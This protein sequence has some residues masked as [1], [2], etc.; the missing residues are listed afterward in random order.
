ME[1]E[2]LNFIQQNLVNPVFSAIMIFCTRIVEHGEIWILAAVIMLITKK[3]RKVGVMVL[4]ALVLTFVSGELLIKNLVCRP[5]PFL[6]NPDVQLLIS[7]PRGYSFPSSHSA[8]S[9]A[10][11]TVIFCFNKKFGTGA[12]ALAVLIAFSRMYLYV[13]YPTDVLCG[14]ILGVAWALIVVLLYK[15]G[16]KRFSKRKA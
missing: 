7:P 4:I 1:I 16:V 3:Y 12:Y 9:F 14:A 5:R 6:A 13:H 10:S 15:Y 8:V 11:A 2:I